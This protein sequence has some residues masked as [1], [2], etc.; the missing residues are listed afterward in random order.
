MPSLSFLLAPALFEVKR[1]HLYREIILKK[2]FLQRARYFFFWG[3][4]TR[5]QLGPPND[6]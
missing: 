5:L 3:I 1:G 4:K 6:N 2:L